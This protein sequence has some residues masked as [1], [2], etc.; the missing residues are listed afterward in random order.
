MET[1][2]KRLSTIAV[3]VLLAVSCDAEVQFSQPLDV[4]N[5]EV[6]VMDVAVVSSNLVAVGTNTM[7]LVAATNLM[8]AHRDAVDVVAV[9]GSLDGDTSVGT[10]PSAVA[11]LASVGLPLVIIEKDGEYAWREQSNEHGIRT[12]KVGTEQFA[13]LRRLWKGGKARPD[14]ASEPALQTSVQWDTATGAFELSRVELGLFGRRVWLLHEQR[15]SDD[16]SG[17]V[18]IRIKKE[19]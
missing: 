17:T 8:A 13:A 12:V 1:L 5:E 7:S 11:R 2:R 19:W 4:S 14:K 6:R 15:D 18:G 10:S 9:H 16:E 3:F